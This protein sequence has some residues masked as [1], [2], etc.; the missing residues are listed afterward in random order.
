MSVTSESRVHYSLPRPDRLPPDEVMAGFHNFILPY[1]QTPPPKG[2]RGSTFEDIPAQFL[3][4]CC[5]VLLP[6]RRLKVPLVSDLHPW[7]QLDS[8]RTEEMAAF[9]QRK[10]LLCSRWNQGL[11]VLHVCF[12][13]SWTRQQFRMQNNIRLPKL[14]TNNSNT[15]QQII[16]ILTLQ[17]IIDILS[18]LLKLK[19]RPF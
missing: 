8:V 12:I 13:S 2:R 7:A 16:D 1:S 15:L 10:F 11:H 3:L 5:H 4:N 14:T 6:L 17:Q 18:V 19:F 9:E